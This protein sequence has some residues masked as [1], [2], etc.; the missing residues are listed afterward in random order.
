MVFDLAPTSLSYGIRPSMLEEG[1]A[2]NG[3]IDDRQESKSHAT[4]ELKVFDKDFGEARDDF[5]GG[6]Q[7]DVT[8]IIRAGNGEVVW[9]KQELKTK[10][11]FGA[12]DLIFTLQVKVSRRQ[13]VKLCCRTA[14]SSTIH[15]R[16]IRDHSWSWRWRHGS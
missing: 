1:F 11:G 9:M 15:C 4:L 5:I 16:R 14:T 6:A 8:E 10:G 3:D 13:C 12:G 2:Q 7:V